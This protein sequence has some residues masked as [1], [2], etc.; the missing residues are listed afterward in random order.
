[1]GYLSV[2]CKATCT[3]IQSGAATENPS[4]DLE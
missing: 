3:D 4:V 2:Y 1:M